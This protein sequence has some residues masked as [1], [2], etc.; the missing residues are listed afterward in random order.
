MEYGLD[1]LQPFTDIAGD[2]RDAG[3]SFALRYLKNLSSAEVHSLRSNGIALGLIFEQAAGNA[4]LG[5]AQGARD[6]DLA[7]GEAEALGV[8][9]T[10]VIFT[11]VDCDVSASQLDTINRYLI[12]FAHAIAP[13]RPGI[14]ACGSVLEHV[15]NQA[16]PWLAGAMGWSG[17]RNYKKWVIKQGVTFSGGMWEGH[18]WPSIGMQYDPNLATNLDWAW[19]PTRSPTI[20]VVPTVPVLRQGDSGPSVEILQNALNA[21]PLL[22]DGDFG[23]ATDHAVRSFQAANRLHVDGIVGEQTWNALD[24]R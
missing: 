9:G 15:E 21:H 13:Y 7:R 12:A 6:G 2:L 4:L 5:A 19:M 8:P 24:R 3:F 1:A 23:S 16:V 20:P 18:S 17:S 14:Y 10:V 22:V 11:T